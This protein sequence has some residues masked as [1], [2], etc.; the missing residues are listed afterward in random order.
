MATLVVAA[1]GVGAV[2][3]VYPAVLPWLVLP[4]VALA[5]LAP[6]QPAGRAR[7]CARSAGTDGRARALRAVAL[8][9]ALVVALMVVVPIA[10][11]RS[12][13]NLLFLDTVVAGGLTEF[14][15]AGGYAAY[16]VGA[17]SAFSLFTLA[18]LTW[19][20][21]AALVLMLVAYAAGL[22]PW[23]RPRGEGWV[24]PAVAAGVVLTTAAVFIRYRFMDELPYQVY[25][26]LTSGA[27]IL[28]GL[29]VVGLVASAAIRGRTVRLLAIGLVAAVWVPVTGSVLQASADGGTGFRA[30]DVEMGRALRGPARGLGGPGGGRRAR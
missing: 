2:V 3:G 24:L 4:V 1:L 28:A 7:G 12:T 15:T 27:A 21:I 13:Q 16:A 22:V 29:V 8:I 23:R 18:P 6:A 11:W 30:A 25:K 9:A 17:T 14:F 5:A 10:M 19:A 20:T 26:G